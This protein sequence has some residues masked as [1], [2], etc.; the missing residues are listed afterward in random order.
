M[1]GIMKKIIFFVGSCLLCSLV[2]GFT[3]SSGQLQQQAIAKKIVPHITSVSQSFD[4]GLAL[5]LI[6]DGMNLSPKHAANNITRYIRLLSTSGRG[7]VRRTPVFFTGNTGNWTS[8]RIDDFVPMEV[9]A[10]RRYM[11]GLIECVEPGPSPKMLI[12]NEVEFLLLMKLL[13]VTPSPVPQGTTEVEV[14]TT[15]Q[16]G[17]QG[18][19]VVRLGGQLAAVTQWNGA[20]RNFKF[21]VP[22]TLNV[23]GL[24]ELSVEENGVAVSNK[25]QVRLLGTNIR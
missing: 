9:F 8:T 22:A 17:P 14:A 1:E 19:K 10:G 18:A 16:L 4:Y 5:Y 12:S 6:V 13:T 3:W 20:T 23:P 21:R 25:V 11:V 2:A 7:N 15:N 24:Y